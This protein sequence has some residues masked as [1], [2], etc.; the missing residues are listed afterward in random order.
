MIPKKPAP[1]LIRGG[2][3]FRKRS[4]SSKKLSAPETNCGPSGGAASRNHVP[5]DERDWGTGGQ[6]TVN[7]QH[8]RRRV[9]GGSSCVP[10]RPSRVYHRVGVRD[11]D[12]W[13]RSDL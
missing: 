3:G 7:P 10:Q 1:D 5:D 8:N 12:K 4:C 2:A 11:M 13:Y 9:S 6:G